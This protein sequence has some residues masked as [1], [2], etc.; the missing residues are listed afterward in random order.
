MKYYPGIVTEAHLDGTYNLFLDDG[1]R[2]HDVRRDEFVFEF[3]EEFP[4]P[5]SVDGLAFE[6][7]DDEPLYGW[8]FFKK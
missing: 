1:V 6:E 5:R 4:T 7:E 2:K 3:E 8:Q